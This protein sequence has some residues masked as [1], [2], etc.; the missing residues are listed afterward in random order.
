MTLP[1]KKLREATLVALFSSKF[2]DP[3]TDLLPLVMEQLKL[4][5]KNALAALERSFL[6]QEKVEELDILID[7]YALDYE[8]ERIS[9][10]EK[11]I[12]RLAVFELLFD[13][14]VPEKVAIAEAVRL[15]RKFSTP[16]SGGFVNGVLDG[17]Y[18]SKG[19]DLD[20]VESSSAHQEEC[21]T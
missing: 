6:V 10:V 12:L 5:K 14:D 13:D 9:S 16:E 21:L 8:V 2:A 4:S 1:L 18:N 20:T 15:A 19:A 17:I 7:K 11:A 3:T